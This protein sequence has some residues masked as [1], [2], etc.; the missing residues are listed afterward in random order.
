MNIIKN[1][2]FLRPVVLCFWSLPDSCVI[3]RGFGSDRFHTFPGQELLFS[4]CFNSR[5]ILLK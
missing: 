4:Y 3:L 1:M 5:K 2:L